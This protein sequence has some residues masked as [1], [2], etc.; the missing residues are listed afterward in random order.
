MV[1]RLTG[2]GVSRI[3]QTK[4]PSPT[5][6]IKGL[7]A[8][9]L[10]ASDLALFCQRYRVPLTFR[11]RNEQTVVQ[12]TLENI[13]SGQTYNQRI[14]SWKP[15]VRGAPRP[16]WGE[17]D[18]L[19]NR[20]P[21]RE[22]LYINRFFWRAVH[23]ARRMGFDEPEETLATT[24]HLLKRETLY[25]DARTSMLKELGPEYPDPEHPDVEDSAAADLARQF[26]NTR[27]SRA[28]MMIGTAVVGAEVGAARVK[29]KGRER[30][31]RVSVLR[32]NLCDIGF[33]LVAGKGNALKDCEACRDRLTSKKR[34][35]RR[36]SS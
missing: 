8:T 13:M 33:V 30:W 2:R 19:A 5:V 16:K 3:E 17:K 7:R 23:H 35:Q 24:R 20:D 21:Q 25:A 6:L 1:I 31:L 29:S 12:L 34:W 11:L 4:V 15:E 18:Y 26:M 36:V 14:Q 22:V 9:S 32:C 28:L 10:F 27:T